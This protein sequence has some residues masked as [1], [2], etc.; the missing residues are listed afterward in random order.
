MENTTPQP[1]ISAPVTPETFS[2]LER[3]ASLA[4]QTVNDFV[5]DR[6]TQAAATIVESEQVIR[7]GRNDAEVV[8]NAIENPPQPNDAMRRDLQRAQELIGD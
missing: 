5:I 2:L 8:L 3:A 7:L 4:G 6:A 1:H